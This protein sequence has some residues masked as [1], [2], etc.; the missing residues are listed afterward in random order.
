MFAWLGSSHV[1]RAA[2]HSLGDT[3]WGEGGVQ[4]HAWVLLVFRE[5]LDTLDILSI[6][7]NE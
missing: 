5:G 6:L 1:G 7:Q 4:V 3:E 2:E